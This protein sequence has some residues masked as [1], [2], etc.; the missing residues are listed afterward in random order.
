[1]AEHGVWI[2]SD[3]DEDRLHRYDPV[4]GTVAVQRAESAYANGNFSR[5]T[6]GGAVEL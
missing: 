3:I 1:M 4:S 2:F 6:A 5:R